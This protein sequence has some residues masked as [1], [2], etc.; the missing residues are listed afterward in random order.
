MTYWHRIYDA[1][2]PV[3]EV[4][5]PAHGETTAPPNRVFADAVA[6]EHRAP[7]VDRRLLFGFRAPRRP[8]VGRVT[9]R[10]VCG[11]WEW[12]CCRCRPPARGSRDRFADVFAIALPRHFEHRRQ[13]HEIVARRR[14]R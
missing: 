2:M 1:P 11:R 6:D 12:T 8:G 3:W 9:V 10:K 14:S 5:Q 4:L 13:H 7:A